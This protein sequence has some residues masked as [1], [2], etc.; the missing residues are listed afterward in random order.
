MIKN[1]QKYKV[2][3]TINV[4]ALCSIHY[5]EFNDSFEDIIETHEAW[6]MV[7]IDRGECEIVADDECF[8]L[9]QGEI[10]FH[11]PHQKHML[12]IIKGICP[13]VFIITFE[14]GSL[15]MK[16][17][18]DKKIVA[19]I[20]TKQY[21]SAI[22]H[23]ASVTFDLPFNDPMALTLN[24][25]EP[26]SLWA[27]DQSI[28][29]R[30]ELMLIEL[31]RK[32]NEVQ[33]A[34]S[35]RFYTKD[36]VTDEFCLRVIEYLE[37]RIYSK[38]NM[39]DMSRALSFSK[40]YIYKRFISSCNYSVVEYF[41]IMKISEAKRLIRES[42]KNFFEISEMLNFSSSHYFST[43]FKRYVGMTPSQY[44]NSCKDNYSNE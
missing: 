8:V 44:K 27:G 32:E 6:E 37:N 12:K 29:I 31:A 5:F 40:S 41:T 39:E 21:I 7:Y 10:F 23:E 24:L 1:Y 34:Q 33:K 36:T 42:R 19:D 15:A 25:K 38:I 11:K 20:V 2:K 22:I 4:D 30:L 26:H 28:L 9:K 14:S 18:E 43:V 35:A 3:K 13:N 16:Y 17:F